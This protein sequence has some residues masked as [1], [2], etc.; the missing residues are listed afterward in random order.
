MG[1][2]KIG[3]LS[4]R[5]GHTEEIGLRTATCVTSCA[6]THT[7]RPDSGCYY[8]IPS[9]EETFDILEN[10]G[11]GGGWI[12]VVGGSNMRMVFEG[13]LAPPLPPAP[14]DPRRHRVPAYRTPR[15]TPGPKASDDSAASSPPLL[16]GWYN[17]ME[18]YFDHSTGGLPNRASPG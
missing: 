6:A 4:R 8:G 15:P 14:G 17:Q 18:Y 10:L 3:V 5:R 9:R 2:A 11:S 12:T 13:A 16:P 1:R 7:F